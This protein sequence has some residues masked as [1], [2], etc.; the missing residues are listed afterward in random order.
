MLRLITVLTMIFCSFQL[1]AAENKVSMDEY[2][3]ALLKNILNNYHPSSRPAKLNET[4]L[5]YV[6]LDIQHFEFQN[7]NGAMHL[8]GLLLVRWVDPKLVWNPQSYNNLSRINVSTKR[9][10]VPDLEFYNNAPDKFI[11]MH[12]KNFVTVKSDGVVFWSDTIE[13]QF[14]CSTDMTNWPHDK[15][16]CTLSLGSWTFD[17][18]E[19]DIMHFDPNT[20]I[21]FSSI[22]MKNM[23]FKMTKFNASYVAKYYSCCQNPYITMDYE[24]TFER[25]SSYA[26]IFRIP[27]F[28][29]ILFT[30]IALTIEPNRSEKLYLNSISF[31]L[32][33]AQLIYFA[34]NIGNFTR[35]TPYIVIFFS[36]SLVLVTMAQLLAIFSLF[37]TRSSFK[38]CLPAFIEKQLNSPFA[39]Y[40]VPFQMKGDQPSETVGQFAEVK[41]D[42]TS[43]LIDRNASTSST[44]WWRLAKILNSL[45]FFAY[46][47]IFLILASVCFV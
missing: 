32:I 18:F 3:N 40:L 39:L 33:T 26:V 15:H 42:D 34:R 14:F 7:R 44:D 5:L 10:W 21:T 38:G 1:N 29:V 25:M 35:Y 41:L 30:L 8:V 11:Q 28:C 46:S 19:V 37:A 6:N 20:S 4:L 31:I 23:E 47:F 45:T 16:E 22:D 9:V 24:M 12:T 17:G 43:N 27:A 36:T 13:A 2:R